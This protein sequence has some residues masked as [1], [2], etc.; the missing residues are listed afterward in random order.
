MNKA[1]RFTA[2]IVGVSVMTLLA[3]YRQHSGIAEQRATC[4]RNIQDVSRHLEDYARAHGTMPPTL[5]DLKRT[6]PTC[7]SAGKD[8]YS[9]GYTVSGG[10]CNLKC[11]GNYHETPPQ[12]I[13]KMRR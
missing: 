5:A 9:S 1:N 11:S 2:V 6:L 4:L 12:A 8:T 3:A 13:L 7:P 10:F